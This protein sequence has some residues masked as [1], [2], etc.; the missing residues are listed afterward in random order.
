VLAAMTAAPMLAQVPDTFEVASIKLSVLDGSGTTFAP[1]PGGGLRVG[2]AS[3]KSLIK[4]A[5][6]L[7]DFQLSGTSG[8]REPADSDIMSKGGGLGPGPQAYM[9]MNDA[10][11]KAMFEVIRKRLQALLGERFQLTVHR[12][13][14]D[15]PMYALVVAKNGVKMKSTD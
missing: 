15:L 6:D 14:K 3:L 13:T 7:R 11:R 10:Q 8:W 9:D 2:G 5:W 4:Y 12:E 1:Q